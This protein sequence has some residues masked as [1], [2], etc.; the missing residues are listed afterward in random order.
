MKNNTETPT[1]PLDIDERIK[2]LNE[3]LFHSEAVISE[4]EQDI[5]KTQ[6][7]TA[8]LHMKLLK[9]KEKEK[10]EVES[11]KMELGYY[12]H[13]KNHETVEVFS[14][15]D[16]MPKVTRMA[17]EFCMYLNSGSCNRLVNILAGIN[18]LSGSHPKY[19]EIFF[20]LVRKKMRG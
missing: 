5:K 20:D 8:D 13:M 3:E 9:T 1:T 18:A 14:F 10:A 4:C 17:E 19:N 6:E 2:K 7:K 11:I 15:N 12:E 16:A